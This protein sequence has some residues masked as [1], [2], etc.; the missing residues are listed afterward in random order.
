MA[1]SKNLGW[2]KV[3]KKGSTAPTNQ[4]M[5]WYDTNVGLIQ[6]ERL[7]I[8]DNVLNGVGGWISISIASTA[9]LSQLLNV[10]GVG[11]V[12][13]IS[14]GDSFVEGTLIE[15]VLRAILSKR[16]PPI[17]LLPI[18][19]ISGNNPKNVEVG[20]VVSVVLSAVFTQRDGGAAG[21]LRWYKD[22][23]FI[24]TGNN[25]LNLNPDVILEE[26][27]FFEGRQDYAVGPIKNDSLGD[28]SPANRILA[29]TDVSNVIEY[30]GQRKAFYGVDGNISTSAGIRALTS[31]FLNPNANSGFTINIPAGTT[32]VQF[33]YPENIRNVDSVKYRELS[34]TEVKNTFTQSIIQV[35]GVNNTLPINYKVYEFIPSGPFG[36]EVNYDVTI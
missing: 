29:G 21:Q 16:V 3:V 26:T 20:T 36:S 18:L 23:I 22:N 2:A 14:D 13:G 8:Y 19:S 25:P 35:A 5:L 11:T 31:N 15:D 1:E 9:K 30:R 24:S 32:K 33:A 27:W 28:P 12:G 34:N 17:Y 10:A 4:D 6:K 7:K